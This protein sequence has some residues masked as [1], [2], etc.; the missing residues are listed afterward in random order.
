MIQI[1]INVLY[2]LKNIISNNEFIHINSVYDQI[3]L[4]NTYYIN[5]IFSQSQKEVFED[6]LHVYES[7]DNLVDCLSYIDEL[8]D[9]CLNELSSENSD[10]NNYI[11]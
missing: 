5:N 1:V 6:L 10:E 11:L 9:I 3:S 8:L 2:D 4:L 7:T